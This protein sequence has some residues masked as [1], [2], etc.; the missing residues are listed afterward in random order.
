MRLRNLL[1]P[2]NNACRFARSAASAATLVLVL[3]A[4]LP[5]A[6]A[7]EPTET[8]G[9]EIIANLAAGRVIIAV[10][11]DAIIVGTVEN[12]IEAG[13]YPPIP[14]PLGSRR[15]GV[16]LGAV[17]WFSVTSQQELARLDREL[18]HLHSRMIP[19]DP[20]LLQP[21]EGAE[22]TDI[23]A[24]GQGILER[25][26]QVVKPLHNKIDLPADEPV[27]ELILAD[28]I[29]GYGP[30]IWQAMFPLQQDPE[31]GD[32]WDTRVLRP[33]Y[34]QF[35]PPEKGEPR[36]LV[37]FHYPPGDTSPT[38]LDLLRKNDP[39]LVRVRE[40]SDAQVSH[41]ADS[42]LHGESNKVLAADAIQFLRAALAATSSPHSRQTM[43]A[44]GLQTGFEWILPPPPE[45]K[46]P[47]QKKERPEGAP[48]LA[49][50]PSQP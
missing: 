8:P 21:Q 16:M 9:D 1:G 49:N 15:M 3:L 43:A 24:I 25:L 10:V 33:R 19:Q 45:P 18:P 28:Y 50:P 40:S 6:Q 22:A 14:V 39:R 42:L 7:Q 5:H 34:F 35:W 37:E 26:N 13:T 32:Y 46:R 20:R 30:E 12:P 4:C 47:G 11:K 48:S 27:V 17:D 44:I 36:T 2:L 29:E 23:Q 41:V 38:L 31:R